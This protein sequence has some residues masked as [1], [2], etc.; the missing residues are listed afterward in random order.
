VRVLVDYRPALT[1]RTGV[2]EYV[3]ELVKA[4]MRTARSDELALFTASWRD[5]P[6]PDAAT[7]LAGVRVID[8]KVPGRLLTLA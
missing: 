6:S 2:G 3:H 8:R 5:R 4:L 1:E 7:E